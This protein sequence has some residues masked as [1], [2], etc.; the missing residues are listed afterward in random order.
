[1]FSGLFVLFVISVFKGEE[2][3]VYLKIRKLFYECF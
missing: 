2:D 1:M 3:S